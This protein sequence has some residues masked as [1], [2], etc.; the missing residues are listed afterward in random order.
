[1]KIKVSP[2]DFV[3]R[4][5]ATL[6]LKPSGRYR[7]YLLEKS[8]WNTLDALKAIAKASGVKL[9]ELGYGGRKDR[10]ARTYQHISVPREYALRS[11]QPNLVLTFLGY[12]DDFIS[13]RSLEANEF[14]ITLR[15]LEPHD[16]P[17]LLNRLAEISSWGFPNYFDDQ[18]FGSVVS[19]GEFFAEKLILGHFR[20]ALKLYLTSVYPEQSADEKRRRRAIEALWPARDWERIE[21][22]CKTPVERAICRKLS[23]GS[24]RSRL[25]EAIE[26]IPR[27]ELSM[28]L[29][30]Y[31]SFLWNK[32]LERVLM[33]C[34]ALRDQLFAVKGKIMDYRFY[35]ELPQGVFQWLAALRIPTVSRRILPAEPEVE[36][37]IHHVLEE[38]GVRPSQ[39]GLR[40]VR[41]VHFSSFLRAAVVIPQDF[42]WGTFTDDEVYPGLMKFTVK[43]TLPPGSFATML[44][45]A[46]DVSG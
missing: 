26:L 46:F 13:A 38:R 2:D 6:S 42:R 29:A 21:K 28:F 9:T 10:Y 41:K 30:A 27:D 45:K 5:R 17:R 31:Q 34:A 25:V 35:R 40:D 11:P 24:N 7:I 39:F 20:G 14:E 15:A 43:F 3:V 4:E 16:A 1:M 44:V 37:S 32:T 23:A 22:L 18:R 36:E 19:S 8:Y 33:S 12:S